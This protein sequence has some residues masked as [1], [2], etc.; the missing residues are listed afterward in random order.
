MLGAVQFEI[1]TCIV[2]VHISALSKINLV[3]DLVLQVILFAATTV[4][5]VQYAYFF[6]SLD[7]SVLHLLLC[8]VAYL[9]K[10][11]FV[12]YCAIV[13]VCFYACILLSTVSY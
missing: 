4:V 8:R 9:S 11:D 6:Y 3:S 1:V 7:I 13:C 12:E 10:M 2:P 5:F